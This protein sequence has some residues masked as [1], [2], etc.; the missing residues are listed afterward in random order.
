MESRAPWQKSGS[1]G[2]WDM[3]ASRR[4]QGGGDSGAAN[5]G[6]KPAGAVDE[7]HRL[8]QLIGPNG[9]FKYSLPS[10]AKEGISAAWEATQE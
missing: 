8:M 4:R 7:L 5:Q 9:R 2:A 6:S 1:N 10:A 3:P